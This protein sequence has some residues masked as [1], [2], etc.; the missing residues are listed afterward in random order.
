MNTRLPIWPTRLN[1]PIIEPRISLGIFFINNTSMLMPSIA[2]VI[3]KRQLSPID[4][5][6]SGL[7]MKVK[8]KPQRPRAANEIGMI[9]VEGILSPRLPKTGNKITVRNTALVIMV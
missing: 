4:K 6:E 1:K 2:E 9:I 3:I 8:V 7:P 5:I